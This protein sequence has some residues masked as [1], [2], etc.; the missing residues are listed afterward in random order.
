MKAAIIRVSHCV[1][2]ELL[3]LPHGAV[4]QDVGTDIWNHGDL[5]LKVDGIGDEVEP[6]GRLREMRGTITKT[7]TGRIT[8]K[9]D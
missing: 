5:L 7:I 6:G 4:V 1:L 2:S 3:Q 8:V 9:W